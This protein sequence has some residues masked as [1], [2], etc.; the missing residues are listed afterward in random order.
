MDERRKSERHKT[1]KGGAIYSGVEVFDCI[2]RN[3]SPDGAFLQ[4]ESRTGVP[5]R[6][7]LI[8]KPEGVKRSCQVAWRSPR[9]IGISFAAPRKATG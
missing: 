6:F 8:I 1:Y 9:K 2:V 4:V 3:L 7:M 5:D